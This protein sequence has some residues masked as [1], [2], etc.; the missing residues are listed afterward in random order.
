M[1]IYALNVFFNKDSEIQN[2]QKRCSCRYRLSCIALGKTRICI[3]FQAQGVDPQ[4]ERILVENVQD[5]VRDMAQ[6]MELFRSKN[7]ASKVF[8]STLCKRRQAEAELAVSWAVHRLQV[9]TCVHHVVFSLV[10]HLVRHEKPRWDVYLR[11][12]TCAPLPP[13]LLINFAS[14]CT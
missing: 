5:C 1:M 10:I 3:S 9:Y 11:S 13:P 8:A 7:M 14:E 2:N 4:A 12:G 6:I